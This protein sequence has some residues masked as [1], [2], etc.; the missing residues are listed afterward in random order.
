VAFAWVPLFPNLFFPSFYY[1][2]LSGLG[3]GGTRLNISQDVFC[4]IDLGNGGAVMDIGTIVTRLPTVAY[5]HLS[6]LHNREYS[7]GRDSDFG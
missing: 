6:V 5:R 3:D 4:V 2:G 1:V 7:V